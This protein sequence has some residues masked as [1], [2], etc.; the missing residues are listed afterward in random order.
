MNYQRQEM[1]NQEKLEKN[2]QMEKI[3]ARYKENLSYQAKQ[4]QVT[5]IAVELEWAQD[6]S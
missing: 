6:G 4:L 5:M 1:K 3:S 2:H